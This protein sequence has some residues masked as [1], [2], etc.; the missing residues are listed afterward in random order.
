[1]LPFWDAV[2]HPFL[3]AL[4][5][6]PIIE[7]GAATGETT[8]KLAELAAERDLVLHSVDPAPEFDVTGFEKRFGRHFQFHR[9]KSH[10]ALERLEPAAAVLI[11]GDHNWYTVHG[12]LVRLERIAARHG[13]PFPLTMLHDVEWPYAR[14]DMYYDPEAIPPE[15]RKPWDRRG[16]GWGRP[17]L[18]EG[19][20]GVNAQLAN[21]IEEGGPRNGVL[22]AVEDFLEESHA[23]PELRIVHGG[24]GIG[25]LACADLLAAMPAV[26]RQWDRLR[27][28]EFLADHSERLSRLAARLAASRIEAGQELERLRLELEQG[29]DLGEEPDADDPT[30][31]CVVGTPRSG[32]SLTARIL[33][34]AGVYLGPESEMRPAGRL[35]PKGFWENRRVAALN[36]RLLKSL[37]RDGPGAPRLPPGWASSDAL[38]AERAEARALLSETF[39]GH[40]LWGWKEA[41]TT[42]VLPFWQQLLP[43]MRFVICL[44]NPLDVAASAE[45]IEGFTTAQAM[46]AWTEH[47]AAALAYT[48]GRPRIFVSY[49]DY[50][51]APRPTVERLWRFIGN[52]ERPTEAEASRLEAPIDEDLRH[53]RTAP[54]ETFQD[55]SLPLETSAMYLIT[56]LLRRAPAES[57]DLQAG[58]KSLEDA[59]NAYAGRLLA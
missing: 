50:L 39:D 42:L 53:H 9:E 12:E 13:R 16:I 27:S 48:A 5:A 47:V 40:R 43:E 58:A 30:V 19:G 52:A 25:V 22:T 55:E 49:D 44:R 45:Q 18:E 10:D 4:D 56:E 57:Q 36:R 24:A 37:D 14:R 8:A 38:E 21:A 59:V 2:L 1:M 29:K 51:L 46:A 17:L 11:D 31:I 6:G 26:R 3:A 28:A 34:L 35:N 32:T 41:G 54:S 23:P 33:T 20:R 15:W 7:I